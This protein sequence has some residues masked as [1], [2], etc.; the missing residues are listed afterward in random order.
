LDEMDWFNAVY[1]G[2]KDRVQVGA[3]RRKKIG[4]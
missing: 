4:Q 1:A 2:T 3:K